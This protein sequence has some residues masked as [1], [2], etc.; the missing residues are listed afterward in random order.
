MRAIYVIDF[1]FF[2]DISFKQNIHAIPRF[3]LAAIDH[4]IGEILHMA[5]SFPHFGVH[6]D[7]GVE[8]LDVA[9]LSHGAPPGVLEI[10]QHLD[11]ER[12]VVPAAVQAAIN[13]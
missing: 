7:G 4:W 2:S 8:A 3:A 1:S 13:F 12:A 11:S 10:A 5:G 6:E 9:A